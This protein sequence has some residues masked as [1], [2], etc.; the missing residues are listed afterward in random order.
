M[1]YRK[2][3]IAL[4]AFALTSVGAQ[5]AP[6]AAEAARL[7]KDLTPVGAEKAGNK[8]G[9]IPAWDGDWQTWLIDAGGSKTLVT[10]AS[11]S[12]NWEYWDNTKTKSEMIQGLLNVNNSP[13]SKSGSMD[14]RI[15]WARMDE[16]PPRAW[17]YTPGQR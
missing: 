4:A 2:T 6:S 8:D 15:N 5:A 12:Y 3:L 9:S 17:S 10:K 14:M 13:A 11:T 16:K 1:T 7:G